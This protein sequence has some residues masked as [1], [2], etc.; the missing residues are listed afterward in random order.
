M[1]NKTMPYQIEVSVKNGDSREWLA[2]R[3]TGG[4]PYEFKKKEEAQAV[5]KLTADPWNHDNY[6]IVKATRED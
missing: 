4:E 2:M 3:P 6:R 5:L 1:G